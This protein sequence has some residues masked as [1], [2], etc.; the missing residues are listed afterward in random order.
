[1]EEFGAD[2]VLGDNINMKEFVL[3]KKKPIL[4]QCTK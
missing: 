1:M 4:I 3:A 2:D